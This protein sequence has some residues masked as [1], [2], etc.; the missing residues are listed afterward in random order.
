MK[1]ISLFFVFIILFSV[2]SFPIFVSA[3]GLLPS[4]E[5]SDEACEALSARSFADVANLLKNDQKKISLTYDKRLSGPPDENGNF[6]YQ[7]LSIDVTSMDDV[8]GC[9]LRT[10]RFRLSM[11]PYMTL[12]GIKF[13]SGLA[14]VLSVLYIVIG[15]YH[16]IIGS[17]TEEKEKGKK[18]VMYALVGFALS[19]LAYTIVNLVQIAVSS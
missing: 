16:F 10:G 17:L 14:G 15:G 5:L 2:F 13:F 8:L 18:T 7:T 3:Q 6:P 11:L 1:K 19:M 12:Y 4:T 9:A